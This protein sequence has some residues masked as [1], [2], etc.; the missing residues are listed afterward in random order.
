MSRQPPAGTGFFS[1]DLSVD[2]SLLVESA[3][4]GARAFVIGSCVYHTGSS[5]VGPGYGMMV[6]GPAGASRMAGLGGAWGG[7]FEATSAAMRDGRRLALRRLGEHCSASGGVGVVGVR[8]TSDSFGETGATRRF[9]AIGTAIG[10][11][12]AAARSLADHAR[13]PFMSHLSG[14][15]FYLL[16]QAGYM[17]VDVVIGSCVIYAR[18]QSFVNTVANTK[19][20]ELET[21]TKALYTARELAMERMQSEVIA[22][23]ADGVVGVEMVEAAHNWGSASITEFFV[24]GTAIRQVSSEHRKLLPRLVV[25]LED[26]VVRTSPSSIVR[27]HQ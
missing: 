19:N 3:G 22:L 9:L 23:G 7:E 20:M 4:F 13:L 11:D 8:I 10:P 2:E 5:Y 26:T 27:E 15:D 16:V 18:A 6:P 12:S 1:S 24:L 25:P 21:F 14:Q 17:P